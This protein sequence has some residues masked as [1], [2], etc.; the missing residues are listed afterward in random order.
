MAA[1]KFPNETKEYRAA[2]NALLEA[3]I[4]LRSAVEAVA[5]MRR[6]LP[7]GGKIREDY[8]FQSF[9][10]GET[11]YSATPVSSLFGNGKNTLFIYSFMYGR[12][13]SIPCP[14]CTS[15]IDYLNGGA[16]HHRQQLNFAVCAAAPIEDFQKFA[17]SRGWSNLMLLS[18]AQNSYNRDYHGEDEDHRQQPMANIFVKRDSGIFHYW[19]SELLYAEAEG[20]PRHVDMLWPLWNVLDLTPG[21]RGDDW[22]PKLFYIK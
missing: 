10:P 11:Q 7:A 9:A 21:G 13:N 12:K 16:Q 5:R 15:F 3:E 14:M 1:I 6:Q 18:A 2:R 17:K 8:L 4:N 22:Y 19:G 20:Q